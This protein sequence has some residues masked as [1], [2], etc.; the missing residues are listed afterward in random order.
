VCNKLG[1]Y[2]YFP[3]D[4]NLASSEIVPFSLS[5]L[6]YCPVPEQCMVTAPKEFVRIFTPL[7]S[8]CGATAQLGLRPPHY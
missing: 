4:R 5:K 2:N 3:W 1:L 6:V 7:V 8:S